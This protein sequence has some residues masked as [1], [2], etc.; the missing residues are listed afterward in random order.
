[1]EGVALVPSLYSQT[2]NKE[3]KYKLIILS[4][5]T[6][7]G[8]LTILVSVIGYLAYGPALREIVLLNLSYGIISNIV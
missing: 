1:M 8:I 7:D 5:T 6:L 4:A 2:Y 3:S